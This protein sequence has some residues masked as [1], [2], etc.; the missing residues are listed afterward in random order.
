MLENKKQSVFS[1][2]WLFYRFFWQFLFI[3]CHFQIFLKTRNYFFEYSFVMYFPKTSNSRLT[4]VP[5]LNLLKLVLSKVYGIIATLNS[6]S[7]EF[8]T[9]RLTP[10]TVIDPFSIVMLLFSGLYLKVKTQLPFSLS[11]LIQVAI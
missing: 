4:N 6:D 3:F 8:T 9:V 5:A 11:T 1:F 7:F 10:L 2:F